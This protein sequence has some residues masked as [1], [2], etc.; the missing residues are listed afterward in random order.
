MPLG[1][2]HVENAH[3]T[4]TAHSISF[5]RNMPDLVTLPDFYYIKPEP[6]EFA[7]YSDKVPRAKE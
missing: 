2:H 1:I 5:L 4:L 3:H 7:T 6:T